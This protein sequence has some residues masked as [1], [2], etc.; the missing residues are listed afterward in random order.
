M[1]SGFLQQVFSEFGVSSSVIPNIID[2]D[3]FYPAPELTPRE[4]FTVVITRN[5]EPIYGLET[6]IRALALAHEEIPDIQLK[7]AGSGPQLQEL[8][9]LVDVLKLG[10]SVTFL[11]R[12][13]R[14]AIVDLYHSADAML[15]PARVDNMPN[16]VL[17]A[18]ACALPVIS[19]NVGGV[20]FIVEHGRTALLV[21]SDDEVAMAQAI[22]TLCK[23]KALQA[24]L[25]KNGRAEVQKY[26][27][28]EIKCKWLELYQQEAA[29]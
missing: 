29:A 15:N 17:E 21:A 9:Q 3:T 13:E 23:D 8:E 2:L 27:W 4:A 28:P 18:M 20:P 16:S 22:L 6:A 11:G 5:L 26:S 12:L 19:T 1:P 24:S 14:D 7:I 25:A 10:N